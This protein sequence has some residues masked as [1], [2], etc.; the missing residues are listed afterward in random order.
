M[1]EQATVDRAVELK[2]PRPRSETIGGRAPSW[3]ATS[4]LD[5]EDYEPTIIRG[6]D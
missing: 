3:P 6:R 1:P 5:D 4:P 2:L